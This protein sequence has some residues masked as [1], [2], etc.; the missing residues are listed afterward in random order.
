MDQKRLARDRSAPVMLAGWPVRARILLVTPFVD[1]RQSVEPIE[2]NPIAAGSTRRGEGLLRASQE[3]VGG[4]LH[5]G[6]HDREAD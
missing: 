3:L 6:A 1:S 5:T 2:C 4:E